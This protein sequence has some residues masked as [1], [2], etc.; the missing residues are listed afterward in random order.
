LARGRSPLGA[1]A[2]DL[3]TEERARTSSRCPATVGAAPAA[4]SAPP[5]EAMDRHRF[6]RRLGGRE[7]GTGRGRPGRGRG[8]S[9]RRR[10]RRRTRARSRAS[11]I[12]ASCQSSASCAIKVAPWGPQSA[13]PS[14]T[15]CEST[16][17]EEPGC[18]P[19]SMAAQPP[20]VIRAS[21]TARGTVGPEAPHPSARRHQLGEGQAA[22]SGCLLHCR[23][24]EGAPHERGASGSIG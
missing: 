20:Q 23:A 11:M 16:T 7:R 3:R 17:A 2:H 4:D 14:L 8:R 21:T 13:R 24:R 19:A 12:G 18:S 10:R 9:G 5:R 6:L 1:S 22:R 15:S